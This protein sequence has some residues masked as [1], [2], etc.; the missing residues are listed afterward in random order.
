MSS[1]EAPELA[2][3][4][5]QE[6]ASRLASRPVGLLPLG[7]I[8][9][10]G[11]HLPLDTDMIIADATARR[12]ML[13]LADRGITALLLPAIPYG[14]SFAGTSFPGTSPSDPG[15]FEDYLASVLTH[16]ARQGYAALICCNAH[17][18]PAHFERIQAACRTAEASTGIPVRCPDQRHEPFSLLLSDEFRAGARHAGG[19]ETSI[20][21]AAQPESIRSDLLR[22][23]PSVWIDL[24]A[25]LREGARTFSE[26]G[27]VLGYFGDPE[28]ASA[29]E[30]ERMLDALASMVVTVVDEAVGSGSQQGG[31]D[32]HARSTSERSS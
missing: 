4:T 11:P 29:E 7:A 22:G 31:G 16:L 13:R 28:S 17:L 19:Y 6:A 18:E 1:A 23:L 5:W 21:M 15:P 14:V 10:H 26:A 12:A 2:H 32:R 27:A 24:P 9:A 8:E 25:K 3:L 30:G 20:L